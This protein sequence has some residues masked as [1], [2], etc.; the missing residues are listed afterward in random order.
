MAF[1]SLLP[2]GLARWEFK[3]AADGQMG[4]IVKLYREWQLSGDLDWLRSLWPSVRQA[5]EFAW[6]HWDPDRDGVI[7]GEQHNTY[8]V[9]FYGPNTMVGCWYLAALKAGAAMAR[10]VGEPDRAEEYEAIFRKGRLAYDALLWNGEYYIQ[11]VPSPEEARLDPTAA[12][13]W[14]APAVVP[15]DP[16]IRYQYGPGCLADQLTG[17]WFAEMVGLG[18]LLPAEHARI[19]L[20]SLIRYNWRTDLSDHSSVQR[21]YALNDEPALLLCTW[22]HG[23]RPILPFPYSDEAW[24]G[25]EYAVAA[26]CIQMGLV[27]QGLE[28]VRGVRSRYDGHRRNPWNEVECGHHYARAM[29]SWSLLLALSGFRYSAP[30]GQL[31]MV[32]AINAASFSCFFSTG[33][34]WGTFVQCLQDDSM[35][36]EVQVAEG[37][38]CLRSAVLRI[39]WTS[40]ANRPTVTVTGVAERP[41]MQMRADGETIL[42][43]QTTIEVPAQQSISITLQL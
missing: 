11:R 28:I 8:D 14:H 5:L 7:D 15:G 24:T 39:P 37:I 36:W 31:R 41:E 29:S 35:R 26:H 30:E 19:A 38:L 12:V 22:P 32:P 17:Q 20:Q 2:L 23:G 43:W 18:D 21:V 9:E 33:A 1:R 3:P 25:V 10:A 27:E 13:P 16:E 40:M 4:S 6:A 42:Q 34:C